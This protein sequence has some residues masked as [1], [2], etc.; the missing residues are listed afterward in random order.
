MPDTY[1]SPAIEA[2]VDYGEDPYY[3]TEEVAITATS[4]LTFLLKEL[5]HL[6]VMKGLTFLIHIQTL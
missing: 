3:V 5:F 6:L 1:R 4:A 2:Y